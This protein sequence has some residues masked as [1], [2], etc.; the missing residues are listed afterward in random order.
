MV[1]I[2]NKCTVIKSLQI[3]CK[4]FKPKIVVIDISTGYIEIVIR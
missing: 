3:I 4:L 2:Y 1:T